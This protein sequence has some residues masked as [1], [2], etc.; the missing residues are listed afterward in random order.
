MSTE[1]T[2][3]EIVDL[4]DLDLLDDAN[5]HAR[6]TNCYPGDVAMTVIVALCGAKAIQRTGARAYEP[7]PDA[8]E[9]CKAAWNEPC[10]GCGR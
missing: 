1:V 5:A 9:A 8:C 2:P 10:K 6:C 4:S 7:P 3:I